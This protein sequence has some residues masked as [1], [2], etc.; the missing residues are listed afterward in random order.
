MT[1][2]INSEQ[3]TEAALATR[4]HGT[5]GEIQADPYVS[6]EF[7]IKGRCLIIEIDGI[8]VPFFISNV[9]PKGSMLLLTFDDFDSAEKAKEITGKTL[10]ALTEEVPETDIDDN[11]A[12]RIDE[13]E[14]YSVIDED[15]TIL[16]RVMRVDYST[17]NALLI[18]ETS[19]GYDLFIPAA[20][21]I[22]TH[23]N[24]QEQTIHVSLPEG[25]IDLN[26]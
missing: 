13:L 26:K 14:G 20:E 23:I 3:L 16:G 5:R 10:Y 17:A 25:L 2:M 18:L 4:T 12:I 15:E 1:V 21:G 8:F 11:D 6:P 22:I 7:F 19:D 24:P 9:R